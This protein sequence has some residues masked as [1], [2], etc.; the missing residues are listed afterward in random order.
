MKRH[1][2]SLRKKLLKINFQKVF[3]WLYGNLRGNI[4]GVAIPGRIAYSEAIGLGNY[5]VATKKPIFCLNLL[6]R[7]LIDFWTDHTLQHIENCLK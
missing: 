6:S 3:R 2:K 1:E 7:F 4:P 5:Y